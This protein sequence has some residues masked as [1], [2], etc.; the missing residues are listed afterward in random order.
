M[1][2]NIAGPLQDVEFIREGLKVTKAGVYHISYK[3]ILESKD[4]T[5]IP[6]KFHIKVNEAIKISSSLTESSTSTTLTSTNLFSLLEGD[7]V[8]LVADLQEH[9]SYKLATLQIIQ[10]G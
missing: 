9:F 8:K 3:V 7:V 6:S 5:I 2:F 1:K 4:I 10:V